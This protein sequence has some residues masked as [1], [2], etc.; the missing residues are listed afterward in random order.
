LLILG[1]GSY[2]DGSALIIEAAAA[3]IGE[4]CV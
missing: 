1:V 3:A 2:A 4:S